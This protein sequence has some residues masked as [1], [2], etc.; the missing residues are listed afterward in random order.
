MATNESSIVVPDIEVRAVEI[1]VADWQ[2][3]ALLA[4]IS[5]IAAIAMAGRDREYDGILHLL[6]IGLVAAFV[7]L[8]MCCGVWYATG[9]LSDNEPV[10]IIAAVFAGLGGRKIEQAATR[11]AAKQLGLELD[12]SGDDS[13]VPSD[14]DMGSGEGGD[15]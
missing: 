9:S 13:S 3:L 10:L 7:G 4:S 15:D 5:A 8:G 6:A 2:M 14:G 1:V 11:K 12:A